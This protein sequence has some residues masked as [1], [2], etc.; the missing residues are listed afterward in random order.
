MTDRQDEQ[1]VGRTALVTGANRGIGRATAIALAQAGADVVLGVRSPDKAKDLAIEIRH[2]GRKATIAQMDVSKLSLLQSD[3]EKACKAAGPID[4]LVNNAGGG[5]GDN[6]I[7]VKPED[8]DAVFAWNVKAPFFLSQAF[9][10]QVIANDLTGDIVNVSSQAALVV[11]PGE[12]VYC[13]AKAAMSHMTRCLA[14]EWGEHG[15]RVNAVAPTFIE[16]DGTAE[17]LSDPAF[18]ADTINRIAALHRLGRPEEVADCIVFLV[19]SGASLV[20]GHNLVIDGGW[21][22]R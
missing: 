2:M 8:F 5:L 21:T 20:T 10:R 11:L 12:P 13:M 6:A 22:V 16:T 9:A 7:D 4:I 19:S 14:V 1:L 18:K 3:F 15:I 17:A